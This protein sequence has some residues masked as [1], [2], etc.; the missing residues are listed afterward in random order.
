MT[1]M[2]Q[3]LE[4]VSPNPREVKA[5]AAQ[6]NSKKNRS[7]DFLPGIAGVAPSVIHFMYT[8]TV[9]RWRV[10]RCKTEGVVDVFQVV[11]AQKPGAV[12][13]LVIT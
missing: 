5:V 1:A 11:K 8:Y 2:L 3:I 7:M 13:T 6:T 10:V 9:D 12:R 4:K